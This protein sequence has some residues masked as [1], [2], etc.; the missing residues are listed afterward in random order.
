MLEFRSSLFL[1]AMHFSNAICIVL[2][3]FLFLPNTGVRCFEIQTGFEFWWI[4]LLLIY[5]ASVV[6]AGAKSDIKAK[7]AKSGC[8][9]FEKSAHQKRNHFYPHLCE[10]TY[11]HSPSDV[12]SWVLCSNYNVITFVPILPFRFLFHSWLF[13]CILQTTKWCL[14]IP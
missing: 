11:A 2:C 8:F 6:Y 1:A 10:K 5:L 3:L 4:C 9:S 14:F 7:N 12:F 13:Q